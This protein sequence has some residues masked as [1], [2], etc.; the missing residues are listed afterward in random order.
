MAFTDK[1]KNETPEYPIRFLDIGAGFALNIGGGNKLII[2]PFIRKNRW[3]RAIKK[4]GIWL[5]LKTKNL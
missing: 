1:A 5:T 2:Q 4:T 3:A